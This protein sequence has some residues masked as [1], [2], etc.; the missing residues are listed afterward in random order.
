VVLAEVEFLM[1]RRREQLLVFDR[2]HGHD[3]GARRLQQDVVLR[4]EVE[5]SDRAARGDEDEPLELQHRPGARLDDVPELA[6]H[7]A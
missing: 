5:R 6:E 2:E 4:I 7:V 3:L 1:H